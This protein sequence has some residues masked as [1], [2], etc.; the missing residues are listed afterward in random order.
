MTHYLPRRQVPLL[1][2]T[3]S[4]ACPLRADGPEKQ[5]LNS[6]LLQVTGRLRESGR[7]ARVVVTSDEP[8]PGGCEQ[9]DSGQRC[10]AGR[11]DQSV[12]QTLLPLPAASLLPGNLILPPAWHCHTLR[13]VHIPPL[14]RA[15]HSG[16]APAHGDSHWPVSSLSGEFLIEGVPPG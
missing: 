16:V 7:R 11:L 10:Y 4:P 8:G 6:D 5:D 12:N 9:V 3:C 13:N 1:P 2:Q 14:H 15:S